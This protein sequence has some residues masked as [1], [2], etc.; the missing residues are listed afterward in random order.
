MFIE[1]HFI[2]KDKWIA[3]LKHAAGVHKWHEGECSHGPLETG[4]RSILN[5]ESTAFNALTE[6]VLDKRLLKTFGYY[7]KFR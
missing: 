7:T 3:L 6:V 1:Y 4:I 5:P 2:P